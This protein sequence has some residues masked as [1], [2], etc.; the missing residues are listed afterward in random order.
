MG[1]NKEKPSGVLS[2]RLPTTMRPTHYNV[3]LRPDIYY[4]SSDQFSLT[5]NVEMFLVCD[6]PAG[7]I[8]LNSKDLIIEPVDVLLTNESGSMI[9]TLIKNEK[10][11]LK[12]I[13]IQK[14]LPGDHVTLHIR[15][16]RMLTN[17]TKGLFWVSY[18][19]RNQTK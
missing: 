19:E 18:R 16:R 10:D 14:I 12:V 15:F 4:D 3:E 5:G 1:K 11:W 9:S 6:S 7:T 13:P 8:Y 17:T 2:D